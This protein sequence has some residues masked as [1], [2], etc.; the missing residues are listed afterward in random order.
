MIHLY[1]NTQYLEWYVHSDYCYCFNKTG[2]I[3][4]DEK[5]QYRWVDCPVGEITRLMKIPKENVK[6]MVGVS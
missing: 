5:I 1:R 4:F 2:L 6:D 3:K